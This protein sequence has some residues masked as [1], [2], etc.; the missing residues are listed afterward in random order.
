MQEGANGMIGNV[1][2]R[3]S[4]RVRSIESLKELGRF[5]DIYH[6]LFSLYIQIYDL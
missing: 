2:D 5:A 1:Q 3:I 4:T 6:K